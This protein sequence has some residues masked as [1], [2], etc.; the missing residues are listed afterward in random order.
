MYFVKFNKYNKKIKFIQKN[1]MDG[2]AIFNL[3]DDFDFT[4]SVD[5]NLEELNRKFGK[6]FKI[7]Y[8]NIT[9]D[10]ILTKETSN[11]NDI[12]YY[13]MYS[14][15]ENRTEP[16][17]PFFIDFIDPTTLS[18]SDNS[19]IRQIHKTNDI[20]GSDMV[21]LVLQINRILKVKKTYLSDGASVNCNGID[22]SLSFFK[23]LEKKQTF[24]MKFGFKFTINE[25]RSQIGLNPA[26]KFKSEEQFN[27][28]INE[29][30]DNIREIKIK[31]LINEYEQTLDLITLIMKEN[32]EHKMEIIL[33]KIGIPNSL[34][35]NYY[36][37]NP[38][39][40]IQSLFTEC[41]EMLNF[42]NK[43]KKT[44][45]YQYLIEIFNDKE[46]CSDYDLF[47]KYITEN[48]RYKIMY[49]DKEIVREYPILFKLLNEIR[50]W[51]SFVFDFTK[52]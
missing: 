32:N 14:D 31:D 45:L 24:Y 52:E 38:Y 1:I 30:I 15:Y 47:L 33:Q 35:N 21:K 51:H 17:R 3:L 41:N 34:N 42:L 19:Y 22:Y 46:K 48:K 10:V 16:Y 4:D 39:N 37:E 5:D 43:T 8:N 13:V 26:L 11:I 50:Q 23:L 12:T 25:T 9:I 20:S 28:K 18:T 7:K 2:G 44:Y 36:K 27:Q 49:N 6:N 40:S 29:L